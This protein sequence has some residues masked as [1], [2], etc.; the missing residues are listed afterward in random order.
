VCL[1][2][3]EF[4]SRRRFRCWLLDAPRPKPPFATGRDVLVVAFYASAE[5]GCYRVL[6]W[7]MPAL[8]LDL[9]PEFRIHTN[10]RYAGKNSLLAALQYFGLE[11]MDAI[12]KDTMRDRIMAGGE[13]SVEDRQAVLDY[14][15][16]D[17]DATERLFPHLI[18]DRQNL[19]PALWRG[20]YMKTVARM[21]WNGVPVDL[22]LYERMAKHWPELQ[23]G[24]IDKVN[25][26]IPVYE[27]RVFRHELLEKWLQTQ[28][29]L[30][31][32]PRTPADHLA[33][34]EDTLR[35]KAE[36]YPVVE[37]LRLARQMTDKLET[38]GLTIGPDGRN[39]CLLSP[40]ASKTGRNQPSSTKFIF[41]A[42]SFLRN[43]IQPP[44]GRALAY[45]DWSGA[46]F[47]IAARLSGDLAMQQSYVSG[48]PYLAFAK[49]IG[50]V[51]ADATK[52]THKVEHD[53]FKTV[54][55][56]V[57]FGMGANTLAYRIGCTLPEARHLL[58]HHR[59]VYARFWKWSDA[60]CD[61]AQIY[62]ELPATFGWKLHFADGAKIRTFR[63][64]SM[65]A[66]CAEAMRLACV[67]AT[68][69]GVM[70]VAPVHDA[71]CIEAAE[72]EI[73]HTVWLT[74]QAMQK[75]SKLVLSGFSLRTDKVIVRRPDHFVEARGAVIWDWVQNQCKTIEHVPG[76][77][78]P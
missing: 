30:D 2:A 64:F 76:A 46:E 54:I 59:R 16:S 19:N 32:W 68:E 44:S 63:N 78:L 45:V 17:V 57:Q 61:Y 20:E 53:L 42:P 47:G 72:D 27:N 7:E 65:Q 74:E 37:P 58:A 29:L 6:D 60:I 41:H 69:A 14:C 36:L 11:V 39:R 49:L 9:F 77:L 23:A 73:D 38:L 8:L 40:F 34:D 4:R 48:N 22:P 43:L 24:V 35:E 50:A 67:F 10:G 21:E 62:G 56:G 70:L 52:A 26:T 31:E 25:E 33:I 15:E 55:L 13:F 71:L 28:G 5:M 18:D 12:Q 75:A 1:V 3:R 51:P 66:N